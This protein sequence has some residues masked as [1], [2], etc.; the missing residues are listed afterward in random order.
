MSV[1][2]ISFY[3]W[4]LIANY[5]GTLSYGDSYFDTDASL[6]VQVAI[7]LSDCININWWI[8]NL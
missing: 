6:R 4:G 5:Q 2:S 3:W 1:E 7:A 8:Y